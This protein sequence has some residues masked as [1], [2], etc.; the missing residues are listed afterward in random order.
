MA[1]G[2]VPTWQFLVSLMG[3]NEEGGGFPKGD[4]RDWMLVSC[5][6]VSPGKI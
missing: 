6:S 3:G 1:A 5:T 2:K 4:R